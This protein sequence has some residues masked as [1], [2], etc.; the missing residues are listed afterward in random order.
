MGGRGSRSGISLNVSQEKKIEDA[1]QFNDAKVYGYTRGA[2]H[3]EYTDINGK[4]KKA[5]T[6]RSNGG[7]Y[8]ASYNAKVADYAKMSTTRLNAELSKQQAIVNDSYQKFTRSAASKS[9]SQVSAF[10]SADAEVR[11][12]KQV[13]RRRKK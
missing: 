9:S 4:I 5:D 2:A 11:M 10:S 7:T 3:V 8:R 1:A 12:I 13:L 6:G